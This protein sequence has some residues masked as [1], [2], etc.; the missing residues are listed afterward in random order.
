MDN[1][2]GFELLGKHVDN[3]LENIIVEQTQSP[4]DEY[5]R[6]RLNQH[7]RK[8]Q[9]QLLIL[10]QLAIPTAGLLDQPRPALEPQTKQRACKRVGTEIFRLQGVCQDFPQ[11]PA[12]Q[13]RRA[14]RQVE[15][16]FAGRAQYAT[17]T[18]WP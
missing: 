2:G 17:G 5:P 14:A 8:Y 1:A 13:I 7:S 16:L 6:R 10:A 9:A 12:R 3:Q 4:V 18:P 15:N 11:A